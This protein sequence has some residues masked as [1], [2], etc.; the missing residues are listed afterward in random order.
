MERHQN[1]PMWS[2]HTLGSL[3]AL[4][5]SGPTGK[6]LVLMVGAPGAGKTRIAR[7]VSETGFALLNRDHIRAEL[8][9]AENAPGDVSRVTEEF[10]NRM[11]YHLKCGGDLVV[12]NANF[13]YVQR[14]P[15]LELAA[16]AGYTDIRIAIVD[17]PLL[18]CL[19]R[20]AARK[21]KVDEE[22]IRQMFD[23]LHKHSMPKRDEGRRF[24]IRPAVIE[25]RRGKKTVTFPGYRVHV[26]LAS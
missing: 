2:Q 3:V 26:D 23:V 10:Y 13:D 15:V 16:E 4:L 12:D 6:R 5:T 18:E 11:R 7:S 8:Y 24:H 19:R 20:N 17:T 25:R 1:A 14:L 22:T 21:R 9:G